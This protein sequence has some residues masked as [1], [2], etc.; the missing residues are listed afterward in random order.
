[1][2]GIDPA[3]SRWCLGLRSA[4]FRDLRREEIDRLRALH[5]REQRRL[6]PPAVLAA[7]G[8]LA[9]SLS[10]F[11]HGRGPEPP[12]PVILAVSALM[13]AS[14]VLPAASL[15][16]CRDRLRLWRALGQD[17]KTGVC[18]HFDDP[19][20][21]EPTLSLGPREN[22]PLM[23]FDLLPASGTV[24]SVNGDPPPRPI[25]AD[26]YESA[27]RPDSTACYALPAEI[28]AALPAEM[29]AAAEIDR[30]RLCKTELAELDRHVAAARRPSWALIGCSFLA[31][32]GVAAAYACAARGEELT[33]TRQYGPLFLLVVVLAGLHVHQYMRLLRLARRLLCDREDAWVLVAREKRAD[34]RAVEF[35]PYSRLAWSFDADPAVW[36]LAKANTKEVCPARIAALTRT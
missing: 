19:E 13:L 35:L 10:I 27:A 14:I 31:A 36:R 3:V 6:W 11:L 20:R 33:W 17:L 12:L 28:A 9:L 30:R 15:L 2:E 25:A 29:L 7:C 21:R 24:L 18:E 34:A 23:E 32:M 22:L 26:V 16:L 4:G 1:M 8:P 5:R